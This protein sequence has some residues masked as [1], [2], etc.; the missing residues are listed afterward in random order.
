M[1]KKN[2]KYIKKNQTKLFF[3][4]KEWSLKRLNKYLETF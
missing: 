4:H 1:I 2:L 3:I